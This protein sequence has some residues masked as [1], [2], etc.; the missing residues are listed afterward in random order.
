M[1][2]PLEENL[3]LFDLSKLSA[4]QRVL[5]ETLAGRG[6]EVLR[7]LATAYGK[8]T[9][10]K[11]IHISFLHSSTFNASAYSGHIDV[12][13]A[14]IL[15][16]KA[17]FERLLSSTKVM[18]ELPH[19]KSKTRTWTTPFISDLRNSASDSEFNIALDLSRQTVAMVLQDFCAS[20]IM[21]HEVAHHASGHCRGVA[22]FFDQ[23]RIHEFYGKTNSSTRGEY[24]LT[25]WEYDADLVAAVVLCQYIHHFLG[26]KKAPHL[27]RAFGFLDGNLARL[28]GLVTGSLSVMFIYLSQMKHRVQRSSYH[29]HPMVRTK[30]IAQVLLRRCATDYAID[31]DAIYDWQMHYMGEFSEELRRIGLFKW[32]TLETILAQSSSKVDR[33]SAVASRLRWSCE[34]WTW[35]PAAQWETLQ[36]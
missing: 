28:V 10:E 23:P 18:R 24:L 8:R 29:P 27:K 32:K 22:H 25:A 30:Y 21:I 5:C 20:F 6:H 35:I 4:G 16:L 11:D 9:R 17:L 15:L 13:I 34:Q 19:S 33:I 1:T 3:P 7:S 26:C 2:L 12:H 36:R 14:S 31:G